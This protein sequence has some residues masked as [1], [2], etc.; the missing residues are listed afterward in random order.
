VRGGQAVRFYAKDRAKE[1]SALLPPSVRREGQK[2]WAGWPGTRVLVTGGEGFVGRHLTSRLLALGA[3]VVA[4]DIMRDSHAPNWAHA[5]SQRLSSVVGD[6]GDVDHVR[7]IL[8]QGPFDF[9]FHFA[10]EA[11]VGRAQRDPLRAFDSN[12]KATYV[13][14]EALTRHADEL[15]GVIHA[16][17]DKVYGKQLDQRG[18]YTLEH[19]MQ[20]TSIY[21]ASKACGDLIAQTFARDPYFL[22]MTITRFCNIYGPHQTNSTTLISHVIRSALGYSELALRTRGESH[23]EYL[24]IDDAID[25]YLKL[26]IEQVGSHS[27]GEARIEN[28]GSMQVRSVYDVISEVYALIG[29]SGAPSGSLG[30]GDSTLPADEIPFQAMSNEACVS[31]LLGRE[32]ISFTEGLTRTIAWHREYLEGSM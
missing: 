25:A 1:A 8:R 23:R 19:S 7:A 15:H 32:P 5:H 30:A 11:E 10:A 13:L 16:S 12:V 2:T 22:P 29:A 24:Y 4:A 21:E 9:V 26:A 18:H 20:P 3:F 28:V 31:H 6:L 14:Y 27:R 17:T